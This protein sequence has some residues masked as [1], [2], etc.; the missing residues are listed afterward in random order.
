MK[1][2]KKK[3]RSISAWAGILAAGLSFAIWFLYGIGAD[4]M[5][6]SAAKG[7]GTTLLIWGVR[8]DLW[9]EVSFWLFVAAGLLLVISL[10]RVEARR[11]V[12]YLSFLTISA[13]CVQFILI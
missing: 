6:L 11:P 3:R 9:H 5:M 12:I 10:I 2:E 4:A 7:N 1:V 13:G 8:V